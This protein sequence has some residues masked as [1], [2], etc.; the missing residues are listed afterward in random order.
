MSA[1]KIDD[2]IE[3][4]INDFY[5]NVIKKEDKELKKI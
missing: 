5:I 3:N 1:N 4:V 2:L